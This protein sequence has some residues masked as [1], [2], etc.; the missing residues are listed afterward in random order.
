MNPNKIIMGIIMIFFF[1]GAID[2]CIGNRFGLGEA[3]ERGFSLMG[4]IALSIMGLICLTP[5]LAEILTPIVVPFFNLIRIDAAMFPSLF[6]SPDSGGW[7]IASQLTSDQT[8]ADFSGLVVSAVM[9]GVVSFSIPAAV[10]L[11]SKEDTKYLAVGIM[12]SF[13]VDPIGCLV[14]G[15]AEGLSLAVVARCL[16]PVTIVG[17]LLAL[18]L[19]F[20]PHIMIKGFQILARVLLILMMFGL[21]LGALESTLGIVVV[22]GMRP[23]G[24]AAKTVG[25]I[26]ILTAGTLPL[27]KV[28][29]R[30]AKLPLKWLSRK[31]GIN[32]LALSFALASLASILPACTVYHQMNVR[33]KVFVAAAIGSFANMLGPHLGFAATANQN[34]IVPMLLAKLTAGILAVPL[35][36]WFGNRLFRDEIANEQSVQVNL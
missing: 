30:V 33:G 13:I 31:T 36:L 9:G 4:K 27:V 21:V 10:G 19:A 8:I 25:S 2:Y 3:F 6:L 5:V 11:I 1:L 29:E 24:E 7:D 26:A 34:M 35:A 22:D 23:I 14:G 32:S 28:I 17:L 12:A 20:I 18:G 16:I 15:L